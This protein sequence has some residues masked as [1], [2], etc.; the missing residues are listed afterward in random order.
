[1]L[2]EQKEFQNQQIQQKAGRLETEQEGVARDI[3]GLK[4]Q[5]EKSRQET[6]MAIKM[7]EELQRQM[8]SAQEGH[9]MEKQELMVQLE[10]GQKEISM[11]LQL[12]EEMMI[13]V[14]EQQNNH[15]KQ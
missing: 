15:E 1:M 9:S 2:I 6:E 8:V 10:E 4:D 14:Q 13:K 5:A 7:K 11:V 3:A 12:K